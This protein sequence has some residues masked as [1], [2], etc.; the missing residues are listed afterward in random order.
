[1]KTQRYL[2]KFAGSE[3]WTIITGGWRSAAI[4]ACAERIK[5]GQ[6]TDHLTVTEED[7]TIH[8]EV[9]LHITEMKY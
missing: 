4:L 9:Q 8:D 2:V 7:G 5:N 6:H 1:M 3:A